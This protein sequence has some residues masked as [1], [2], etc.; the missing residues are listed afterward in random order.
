MSSKR[1]ELLGVVATAAT[2]SAIIAAA[3]TP[4][5]QIRSQVEGARLGAG[6][7]QIINLSATPDLSAASYTIGNEE[8]KLKLDVVHLPYQA[9][10]TALSQDT[11]LY[12]KVAGGYLQLKQDL[13]LISSSAGVGS[14][15]SKWAA[16]SVSGG[17][18]AKMRL[19]NGFTLEP[20]L[21]VGIARLDNSASYSGA[22]SALE[23][24]LDGLLFNWH[25]NAWLT[26]PSLG[27]AWSNGD[28]EGK[29]SVRGHVA[30]S[31]ISTFGATDPLQEF[32]ETANLYSVRAEYAKPGQWQA[33]GRPLGWVVY[34]SYAGFFGANRDALGFTTVAELGGGLELPISQERENPERL[35]LSAGYLFGPDVR[36][37]SIGLSLQY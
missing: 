21:D 7:A 9:R 17:L 24:L 11:D 27:F 4:P 1:N 14:V 16:Y 18:L 26:T 12:W 23:P 35:R 29:A 28:A 13:P 15:G 33:F 32:N 25:T 19:G 37:W 30:R 2:F 8:P 6:Y 5:D 20:A 3:Q 36:G 22:A 10:W 34:G 31:W